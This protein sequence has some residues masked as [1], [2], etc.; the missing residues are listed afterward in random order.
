VPIVLYAIAD[1][2]VKM[3]E[4]HAS[5]E[6]YR[7]AAKAPPDLCFPARLEE[8]LILERA[9]AA[10]PE[11]ARAPYYLGNL[12]YN[13]RRYDE[14]IAAWESS[15]R[16]DSECATA[17]RNLGIAYCNVRNDAARARDAFERA[18]EADPDDARIFY[19]RD[20][21]WKRI[22][23]PPKRRMEELQ[24]HPALC[25]RRD[26]LS[27]ELAA[28]LNQLREPERALEILLARKFQPWEGGEGLVLAQF[29]RAHLLLGA[30]ALGAG[31]GVAAQRWFEAIL[32]LPQNLGEAKH[33]LAN[34]SD[35]WF[36]LG[37]SHAELGD[38]HQ[39]QTCWLRAAKSR[40]DFCEMSVRSVSEMTFW[41]AMASRCLGKDQEATAML[42][43][44]LEYSE[45]L[46]HETPTIDYFATSLP[47]MLLFEDDLERRNRIEA[48][49]LRGQALFG[50]GKI[51]DA[52]DLMNDVLQLNLNHAG[53]A[54]LLEQF[55]LLRKI[56]T[57]K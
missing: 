6:A 1:V 19:E 45:R 7:Q 9:I 5:T 2:C 23:E 34:Q 43:A 25:E 4:A 44:I 30:R 47:A 12:L 32:D 39:A 36:W 26:D 24:R 31:D 22:G 20:Q 27:V 29:T 48:L 54:D 46:E 16:L 52:R 49:F 50:M 33:L 35:V 40:G 41:S 21:L 57:L 13:R 15:A 55:D 28:L 42:L 14:A 56:A 37:A 8:F 11:D 53:A 3:S 38:Q 51:A 10:H 17:W 18:F